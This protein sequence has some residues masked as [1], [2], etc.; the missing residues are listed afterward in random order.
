MNF[1]LKKIREENREQR[2]E[3]REQGEERIEQRARKGLKIEK[4]TLQKLEDMEA[5][6]INL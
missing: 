1:F 4:V 2:E 6:I 5:G 3:N